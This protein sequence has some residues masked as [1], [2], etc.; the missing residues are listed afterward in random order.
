MI[1]SC[2]LFLSPLT[3]LISNKYHAMS[4]SFTC[5]HKLSSHIFNQHVWWWP[6]N[7]NLMINQTLILHYCSRYHHHRRR[8]ILITKAFFFFHFFPFFCLLDEL[9]I[10]ECN[11]I[12]EDCNRLTWWALTFEERLPKLNVLCKLGWV[13]SKW[14]MHHGTIMATLVDVY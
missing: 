2:L 9:L 8:H 5:L 14:L 4:L 13:F 6:C 1:L 7:N 12:S 10:L 3:D 11:V